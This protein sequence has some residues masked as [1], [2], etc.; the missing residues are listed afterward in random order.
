M[1]FQTPSSL[2][3]RMVLRVFALLLLSSCATKYVVPG[4]RFITP[5]SQGGVFVT[6]VE[7]Q[8]TQAIQL[9]IN[10]DNGSVEEGV[11]YSPLKR[12]G[13]QFSSS[14]LEQ[15]DFVWSH[16]GSG[17]SMLGLK[18]QALGASKSTNGTGHKL[19]IVFMGGNNSHETDDK[20]VEF[21]LS[22]SEYLLVYGFRINEI[23]L[24]YLGFSLATYNF[25]GA[26]ASSNPSLNG[27]RPDYS[28]QIQSLVTGAE[29][30]FGILL[31][32]LE[33]S[34]QQLK[35]NKTKDKENISF[36]YSLGFGF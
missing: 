35:T 8:Q 9:T 26:I 4:N 10:T 36:G 6:Q 22:G 7:Y 5:E 34:Y 1:N 33:M 32:K 21:D 2:L 25:N 12:S 29:L 17:N 23:V 14:L 31:S 11:Y 20:A 3:G 13:F 18:F 27:Q 15:F 30:S 16:T 19:A 24:P 28:T